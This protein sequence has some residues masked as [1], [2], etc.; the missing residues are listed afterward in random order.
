MSKPPENM[1][2]PPVTIATR[3]SVS[4]KAAM[5]AISSRP[6]ALLMALTGG[7]CNSTTATCP[8]MIVRTNCP[9]SKI[10]TLTITLPV[11]CSF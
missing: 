4:S 9:D 2:A 8:S 1:R 3:M 10:V 6:S 7:C 11:G 5:V